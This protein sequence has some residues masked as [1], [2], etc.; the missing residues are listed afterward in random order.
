[1][2]YAGPGD[3]PQS[4]SSAYQSF[5]F[6]AG[7]AEE[8]AYIAALRESL[9]EEMADRIQR[10]RARRDHLRLLTDSE[11]TRL[12]ES[13]APVLRDIVAS[14]AI[15]PVIQEE[16]YD[17]VD[18]EWVSVM[19]WGSDGTGMGVLIPTEPTTADRVASL[20]GQLQEWEIEEL[21]AAGRSATWP[22]CPA[23]PNSHPLEPAAADGN[24][25]VWR[26]PRSGQVISQVGAL[27]TAD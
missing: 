9:G 17:G 27:G 12:R 23:H 2:D 21:A 13:M 20:A 22:E 26:C 15:R 4:G 11:R 10:A 6:V 5:L 8:T 16:T 25:A 24:R 1:M 7:S 14:G 19:V 18:D 3:E